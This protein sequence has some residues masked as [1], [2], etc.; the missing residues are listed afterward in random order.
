MSLYARDEYTEKRGKKQ[1]LDEPYDRPTPVTTKIIQRWQR[2]S[3]IEP[4]FPFYPSIQPC[5]QNHCPEN[6]NAHLLLE[7]PEKRSSRRSSHVQGVGVGC[8]I[9]GFA[10]SLALS[11]LVTGV[12]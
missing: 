4:L 11:P 10:P 5:F 12:Q 7:E 3:R 8:W 2:F 9:G 6:Q 1:F